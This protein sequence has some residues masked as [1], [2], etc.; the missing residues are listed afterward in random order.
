MLNSVEHENFF[1]TSGPDIA[2][3]LADLHDK[4]VLV[5]AKHITILCLFARH[6][7]LTA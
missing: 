2:V 1:I 5:P 4:S 3:V 6:T 7:T